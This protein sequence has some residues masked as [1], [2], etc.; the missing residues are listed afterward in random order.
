MVKKTLKFEAEHYCSMD[1]WSLAK[2]V[3][4]A[5]Y[6]AEKWGIPVEN[7]TFTGGYEHG[8]YDSVESTLNIDGFRLETDAE[9]S[10]R[11][12]KEAIAAYEAKVAAEAK[13]RKAEEDREKRDIAEYQRLKAK[14]EKD[15]G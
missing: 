13:A 1:D 4:I 6:Y 10:I 14:F 3:D 11:E 9:E 8:Y 7:I 5:N 12:E 2:I 15:N